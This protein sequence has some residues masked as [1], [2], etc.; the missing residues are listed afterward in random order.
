MEFVSLRS[1]IYNVL[2]IAR[3][4]QISDDEPISE[5]LA[6]SWIHKYKNVLLK[7]DLDKGKYIN[8]DYIQEYENLDGSPLLIVPEVQETRT[9]Y[10]TDV[11]IPKTIDLNFKSGL[12]FIGDVEGNQIQ[13]VP[14]SRINFQDYKKYTKHSPLC[15]LKN[16]YIYLH[17]DYGL[18]RLKV[19]ALFETPT[20]VPGFTIDS[21]YPIPMNMVDPL[22]DL[23]KEK[24]LDIIIQVSSDNTN[25][26]QHKVESNVKS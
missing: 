4:A 5:K 11:Q 10:R 13:L 3:G 21:K 2:S 23:I 1:L 26:T 7:R 17:N 16:R 12:V 24:E 15:Y 19:R 8:P 22:M 14:E 20:E 25:D 6:E 18:Q 9:V